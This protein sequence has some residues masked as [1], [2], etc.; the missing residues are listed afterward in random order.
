MNVI[1]T[2][3]HR[4]FN[5]LRHLCHRNWNDKFLTIF[6]DLHVYKAQKERVSRNTS[7]SA[8]IEILQTPRNN[9]TWRISCHDRYKLIAWRYVRELQWLHF[10]LP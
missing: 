5:K 7:V 8:L 6:T 2:F 4:I 9:E 1:H 3:S 10:R